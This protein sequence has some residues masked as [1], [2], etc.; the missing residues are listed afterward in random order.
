MRRKIPDEILAGDIDAKMRYF[1]LQFVH[2]HN[3]DEAVDKLLGKILQAGPDTLIYL[4]APGATGKSTAKKAT[5][6]ALLGKF[7]DELARDKG[8]LLFVDYTMRSPNILTTW[9]EAFRG[10][11]YAAGE[12]LVECKIPLS[13]FPAELVSPKQRKASDCFHRSYLNLLDNRHPLVAF[14]D[15][16]NFLMKTKSRDTQWLLDPL[17]GMCESTPHVLIG[18]PLLLTLRN[19]TLQVGWRSEDIFLH[20]YHCSD[21]TDQKHFALAL[22]GFEEILPV[23]ERPDLV[24]YIKY[25]MKGS[26]GSVGL[27][28]R[29]LRPA[30]K[31]ALDEKSKT[32][33]LKHLERTAHS[34]GKLKDAANE[35]ATFEN[36]VLNGEKAAC[37]AAMS[38]L[39]DVEKQIM[40][41]QAKE[42][43]AEGENEKIQ[44]RG[45]RRKTAVG[46]RAPCR[47]PIG[48]PKE[49]QK[50]A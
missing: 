7:K 13:R 42:A 30:L 43:G 5:K 4:I 28:R 35:I 46:E 40:A 10:A 29:W 8:R 17:I 34:F 14:W 21:L 44:P 24:S 1:D 27:L 20:T 16:A 25:L 39:E 2:H 45:T 50:S 12:P 38:N 6:K 49:F 41:Q 31:V 9:P 48:I 32:I 47:D 15:N 36:T 3:L 22:I 11:L 23:P 33:T 18:T 19:V 37:E 26:V